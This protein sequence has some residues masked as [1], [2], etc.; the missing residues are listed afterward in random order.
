MMKTSTMFAVLATLVVCATPALA[1]K[2]VAKPPKALIAAPI[3]KPLGTGLAV[4]DDV[5]P[6]FAKTGEGYDVLSKKHDVAEAK[7][8]EPTLKLKG[9]NDAQ[10]GS[11]PGPAS[12]TSS[13]A[14]TASRRP[15]GSRP[16]R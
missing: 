2:R 1:E 11:V 16:P 10:V 12:S 3:A 6:V 9:L 5:A 14:G 7:D 15:S 8:A 4:L 13:T